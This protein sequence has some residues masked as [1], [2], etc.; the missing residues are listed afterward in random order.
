VDVAV[1]LPNAVPGASGP[2]LA[3]WARRAEARGFSSLAANDRV[4]Y[5]SYEPLTA[6]A[7][8]AAVTE[9]IGLCPAIAIGPLRVSAAV[10]AKQALSLQALSGGRLTLGLGLGSRESDYDA[11]GVSFRGRG[12]KL[13]AMIVRMR[14]LWA[15]EAMGPA[16]PA[17]P[18]VVGGGVQASF[19][20]AA[21]L[22]AGW[23]AGGVTAEE[24]AAGATRMREAWAAHGR[25]GRPRL[26]GL[27]YFSLGPGAEA[28][29]GSYLSGYYAWLGKEEAIA[30]AAGAA[31]DAAGV[32]AELATFEAGGC[33]ELILFPCAADPAQVDLLAEA[34]DL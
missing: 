28:T 23:M 16:A 12:P 4:A 20:R 13:E 17:P 22:G 15:G 2:Q 31:T 32:R 9:R 26:I 7:A 5:G 33:D 24:F 1:A 27:I 21:R 14:E 10:L 3:E 18:I 25:E 8:A 11:A 34:A 19:D 6:L 29:A 30:I